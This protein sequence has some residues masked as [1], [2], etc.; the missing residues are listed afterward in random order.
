MISS[1]SFGTRL[2][3][4]RGTPLTA[5]SSDKCAFSP[6]V[7]PRKMLQPGTALFLPDSGSNFL[8]GPPMM[9]MSAACTCPHEFG[10][11]V[12]WMRSGRGVTSRSSRS[13]ATASAFAFVSTIAKP[14][15][16]EPVHET[17][18]PTMLPGSTLSRPP[19]RAGSASSFGTSASA[20]FGK[21]MF[22]S[23]V[24]RISPAEYLSARSAIARHSATDS[25]PAGTCTPTRD[26]PGWGCACTPSSS[27]RVKSPV[28]LGCARWTTVP[29]PYASASA[30]TWSRKA[31]TPLSSISHISRAF[32]RSPRAPSSRKMRRMASQTSTTGWTCAGTHMS[33]STE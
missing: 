16:C 19:F 4:S 21:M 9:P 11:P 2:S 17:V 30:A 15:N 6:M 25:R 31:S 22:C 13:F 7:P 29:R 23:T 32:W 24:A 1:S 3:C 27:R 8:A 20:T 28:G 33:P 12:Q 14:Q 18:W 10:Q 5:G 26:R